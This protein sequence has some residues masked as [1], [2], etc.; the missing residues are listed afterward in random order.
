[1]NRLMESAS[2]LRILREGISKGHWSLTDLDRPSPGFQDATRHVSPQ[3]GRTY[4]KPVWTN[5]LRDNTDDTPTDYV[6]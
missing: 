6:F 1:M 4:V 5:P 3:F 2:L